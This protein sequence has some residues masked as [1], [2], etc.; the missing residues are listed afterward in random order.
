MKLA[1]AQAVL[2]ESQGS[3]LNKVTVPSTGQTV[4]CKPMT[5]G[6]HKTIAKMSIDDDTT[7][8]KF[9]CALIL[10][11]SDNGVDFGKTTEIDKMSIVFQLKQYNSPDPLKI[12][13]KCPQCETG[14][15]V[16]PT[17]DDIIKTDI[18][19]EYT[20]SM[21]IAGVKFEI[22]IGIPFI[23]DSLN[24]RE[25]CDKRFDKIE[26]DEDKTK[27]AMFV[28][29]YEMFLMFIRQVKI[30]GQVI[31]DYATETVENRIKFLETLSEGLIDIKEIGDFA[32][33]KYNEYG[34]HVK[35]PHAECGHEYDNLFSPES[36]FF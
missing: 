2:K 27:L 1:D 36:F 10:D 32:S 5:L 19:Q 26:S 14:L 33:D 25:F 18:E 29:S 3:H 21:E 20:K 22:T 6:H 12:S 16:Q 13:L 35:C 23:H 17:L 9:L 31:E 34:Y 24:Y 11:L 7:F 4:P 8:N 30:N 28:A 15:T